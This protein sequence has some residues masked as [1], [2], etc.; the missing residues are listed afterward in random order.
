V[1][2]GA[3]VN[4]ALAAVLL[5]G[6]GQA[7]ANCVRPVPAA[8]ETDPERAAVN[9]AFDGS[10]TIFTGTVTAMV[11]LPAFSADV[12]IGEAQYARI[13]VSGWWKGPTK[14]KEVMLRSSRFRYPDGS[15][16]IEAHDY[17]FEVGKTYLVYAQR[18]GYDLV[19]SVCTRTRPIDK[20]AADLQVLD[21]LKVR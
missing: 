2:R 12:G 6:A 13:A 18:F 3:I 5:A 14:L 7:S 19:T 21:T 15:G 8:G 9:Y 16:S 1:T 17:Q 11:Y 10:E 4:A 20:A